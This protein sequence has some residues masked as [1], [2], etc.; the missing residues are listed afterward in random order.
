MSRSRADGDGRA[1][2]GEESDAETVEGQ[3]DSTAAQRAWNADVRRR[4]VALV[5][6]REAALAK[7]EAN[8]AGPR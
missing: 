2:D 8:D 7:E 4:G 1:N 3:P 5:K 6:G